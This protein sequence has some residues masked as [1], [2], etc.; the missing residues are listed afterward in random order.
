MKKIYYGGIFMLSFFSFSKVLIKYFKPY[1][2]KSDDT[3]YHTLRFCVKKSTNATTKILLNLF[4]FCENSC[5]YR[6]TIINSAESA[7]HYL[8]VGTHLLRTQYYYT[9]LA[10]LNYTKNKLKSICKHLLTFLNEN[11]YRDSAVRNA[12][13]N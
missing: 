2:Y 6:P 11:S 7:V 12:V 3:N 10:C 1:K 13:T 4:S 9:L 5:G 8:S